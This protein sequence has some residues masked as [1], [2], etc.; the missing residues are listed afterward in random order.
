MILVYFVLQI[1][2]CR[3]SVG[4]GGVLA[5]AASLLCGVLINLSIDDCDLSVLLL[6]LFVI[7]TV[8]WG[9]DLLACCLLFPFDVLDT[10]NVSG[11]DFGVASVFYTRGCIPVSFIVMKILWTV[12]HYMATLFTF[13][14]DPVIGTFIY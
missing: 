12:H 13:S 6:S 10:G 14:T 7:L 11:L 1:L 4:V 5:F 8:F 9:P 2:S 3:S